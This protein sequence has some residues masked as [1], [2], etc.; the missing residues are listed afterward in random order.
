MSCSFLGVR[1]CSVRGKIPQDRTRSR[2]LLYSFSPTRGDGEEGESHS[3]SGLREK[4]TGRLC[5][6]QR[7]TQSD[8]SG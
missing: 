2:V 1:S 7:A 8:Q 6:K 5:P 3:P 4:G